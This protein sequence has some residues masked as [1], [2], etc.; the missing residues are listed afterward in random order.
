KKIKRT[1]ILWLIIALLIAAGA[2]I[3]WQLRPSSTEPTQTTQ[4]T[5]TSEP[6]KDT[7]RLIATGDMIPHDAINNAA[8]QNDENYDYSAMFGDTK[9]WCN[10]A[11]IR[12]C[13][14]PTLA[15]GTEYGVTGYPTFNA[16][17][18]F[19]QALHDQGCNLITLGSNH[20]NDKSQAV[21]NATIDGWNNFEGV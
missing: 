5:D 2:A 21:I 12:F 1:T 13:N 9:A 19:T 20:T 15:G 17:L 3:W 11:D 18:E 10:R 4:S 7:I 6:Q 8:K 16:P 14:Q